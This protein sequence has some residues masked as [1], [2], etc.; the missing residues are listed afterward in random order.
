MTKEKLFYNTLL[1]TYLTGSLSFNDQICV[2]VFLI[3]N[4]SSE[5]QQNEESSAVMNILMILML[6]GS[7]IAPIMVA[8]F[9]IKNRE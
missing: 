2:M 9:V 5:D 3:R 4:G 7:I 1:R 8:R 6:I